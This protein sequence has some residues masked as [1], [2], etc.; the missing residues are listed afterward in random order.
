MTKEEVLDRYAKSVAV[1]TQADNE[2][3]D[4]DGVVR[5]GQYVISNG[6]NVNDPA[7]PADSD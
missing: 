1:A 7:S 6:I 3:T 2:N 5:I 4:N